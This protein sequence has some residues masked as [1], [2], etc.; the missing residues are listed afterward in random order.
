MT[1][2]YN[3][4]TGL[5]DTVNNF[6]KIFHTHITKHNGQKQK[7]RTFNLNIR[8][9]FYTRRLIKQRNRLLKEVV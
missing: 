8:K 4:I 3:D 6:E 1:G 7:H 2:Y 5:G 9:I